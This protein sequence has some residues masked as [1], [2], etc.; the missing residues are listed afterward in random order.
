MRQ[1]PQSTRLPRAGELL[2]IGAVADRTGVAVS[3]LRFYEDV[4]LV[5]AQRAPSGHRRFHRSTIRRVSFIRICQR[6]G[7]SLDDIREQLARLPENRTPTEADWQALAA[8]FRTDID[9]RIAEL[10]QLRDKLDGC[11]GCG[12]LSLQKC[13]L[14]NPDDVARGLGNGPRYLLGDSP[15][16]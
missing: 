2:G 12:C 8:K 15:N 6:L 4:G 3:A 5:T 14:Y 16:T 1:V 11:I 9:R 7:Y 13:A 10:G